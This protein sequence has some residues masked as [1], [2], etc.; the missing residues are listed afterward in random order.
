MVDRRFIASAITIDLIKN[1]R[2]FFRGGIRGPCHAAEQR[3][4]EYGT[5]FS[6]GDG[7]RFPLP[8]FK[9][10]RRKEI[11]ES[12]KDNNARENPAHPPK[13]G[14]TLSGIP[15]GSLRT[16]FLAPLADTSSPRRPTGRHQI[17]CFWGSKIY[18]KLKAHSKP[19]IN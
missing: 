3:G 19:A 14:F 11:E 10:N 5:G 12:Q 15:F 2:I 18:T 8:I 13:E 16:L 17:I 9:M 1:L 4:I 7:E 6:S